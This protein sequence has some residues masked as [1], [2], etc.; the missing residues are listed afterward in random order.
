MR[1]PGWILGLA[2]ASTL[3]LL[4]GCVTPP[5]ASP[6]DATGN[7]SAAAP[8][9]MAV[10]VTVGGGVCPPSPPTTPLYSLAPAT[11]QL[12]LDVPVNL[13][14]RNAG[15]GPHDL[16]ID[17]LGVKVNATQAGQSSSVSFTPA[18]TG[19]FD[20]YCTL[21]MAPLDHRSNGMAGKVTVS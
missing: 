3:A 7:A 15:C 20:M 14:L 18:K 11:L 16:M 12:K 5:P 21:G 1:S 2:L 10:T 13:T 8:T 17:G 19:T 4:T 9:P 6:T